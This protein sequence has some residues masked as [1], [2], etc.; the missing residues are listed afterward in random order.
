MKRNRGQVLVIFAVL[1]P[2][3]L[4]FFFFALSLAALLDV[5]AHATYALAVATRAGSRHVVYADYGQERVRFADG[6]D[7]R[8]HDVFEEALSLST[9][10]LGDT[11]ENIAAAIHVTIGYGTPQRPW[12]SPFV[13]GRVHTHPTVAAQVWIPVRVWGFDV[14]VPIVSETE[15]R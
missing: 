10:G 8:V 2:V 14:R 9:A 15:V 4:A 5:R 3:L 6:V 11:P 13:T 7:T 12:S 1:V